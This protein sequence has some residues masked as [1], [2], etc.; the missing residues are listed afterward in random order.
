M[1]SLSKTS[2]SAWNQA[3]A[4]VTGGGSG[5]GKALTRELVRRGCRVVVTD[6]HADAAAQTAQD[7]GELATSSQVDVCDPKAVQECVATTVQKYGALHY[8]F[9]NAGIGIAGETYE[10]S[11]AEWE[12]VI[13]VN[14][15]G[16][17]HGI[18]AAYPIMVKQGHG[19][20]IN[21]ASLAG[22]GPSPFFTPYAMTKHAV[23]GLTTSLRIE[24][25]SLGV[26]V[27]ALCPAAIET[28]L[29]DA[30]FPP[31]IS[32][33]W[34]P[35]VRQFLTKMAGAPYPVESFAREAL[36]AVARNQSI[37]VIPGKA[38]LIWRLGRLSLSLI[39]KVAVKAVQ[40]ERSHR[41]SQP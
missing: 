36:D 40:K 14:I 27:S 5:I 30:S 33:H 13:D 20:I 24:A 39:E 16:V 3:T 18:H 41:S 34:F 23:V 10:I 19:H 21:T 29:L 6:I 25:A 15:R 31:G 17:I 1:S 9:N 26:R 8:L 22:L 2:G 28:P 38:R 12:K 7:C 11:L 35:N 32:P 4:I 37:I